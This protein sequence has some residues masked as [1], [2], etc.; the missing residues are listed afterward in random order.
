[1]YVNLIDIKKNNTTLEQNL[2]KTK[3]IAATKHELELENNRL[4]ELLNFQS[5]KAMNL[6]PANV[7]A[8]DLLFSVDSTIRIDKGDQDGVLDDMAVITSEGVVGSIMK[9][10]PTFS[11]VLILT[12]RRSAIDAISQRSRAR[13]VIS[14]NKTFCNFKYLE[15]LDDIQVGDIVV[16]SGL[17][18]IFPKGFP[19]GSV[20]SVQKKK[21][22]HNSRSAN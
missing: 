11:D 9:A 5:A 22:W 15:R 3:I 2:S 13:G 10:Y 20:L 8:Y 17:D 4:R 14:G 18:N 12:D 7:I 19:I 1:M 6:K 16:T 21:L